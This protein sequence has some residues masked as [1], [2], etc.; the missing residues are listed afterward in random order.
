MKTK[1]AKLNID[2]NDSKVTVNAFHWERMPNGKCFWHIREEGKPGTKSKSKSAPNF[3]NE[4]RSVF[5]DKKDQLQSDKMQESINNMV[6]KYYI[7]S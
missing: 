5:R 1:E 4:K 6:S 3:I 7:K 2:W